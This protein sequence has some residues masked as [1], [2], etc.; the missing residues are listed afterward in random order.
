MNLIRVALLAVFAFMGTISLSAQN[1]WLPPAPAVVVI[2]NQLDQLQDGP[3]K[4][5]PAQGA[6]IENDLGRIGCTDCFLKAV[7]VQF[8]NLTLLKLKE[9]AS[10]TGVAVE[11]VRALMI[12]KANNNGTVLNT[13]QQGFSYMETIL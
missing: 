12:S 9:G 8:L 13:I 2:T 11:E 3:T 7:K 4:T 5:A 1:G 6:T 10:D